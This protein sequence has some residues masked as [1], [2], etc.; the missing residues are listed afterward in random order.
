MWWRALL[1]ELAWA[2]NYTLI[3]KLLCCYHPRSAWLQPC[4]HTHTHTASSWNQTIKTRHSYVW[5]AS[6]K[7]AKYG[8]GF[9]SAFGSALCEVSPALSR[10]SELLLYLYC[11]VLTVL[12]L[13]ECLRCVILGWFKWMLASLLFLLHSW[14]LNSV[15]SHVV[16]IICVA[17][18][19]ARIFMFNFTE[20]LPDCLVG[21]FVLCCIMSFCL[22]PIGLPSEGMPCG[23]DARLL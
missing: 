17:C 5:G 3:K 23:C 8:T 15:P 14:D 2:C 19:G 6:C 16:R 11:G 1:Y 13:L 18:P 21:T 12:A 10:R 4:S 9:S 7:K 22:C 20:L